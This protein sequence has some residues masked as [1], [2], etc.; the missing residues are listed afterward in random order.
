MKR[1]TRR[2]GNK[3]WF[4]HGRPRGFLCPDN[5]CFN[6]FSCDKVKSLTCPYLQL[7]DKLADYEDA[8]EQGRIVMQPQK[9]ET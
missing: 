7:L 6:A 4:A 1:L 5:F 8:E 3:V 2:D 9:E